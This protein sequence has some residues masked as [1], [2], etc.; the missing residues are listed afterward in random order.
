LWVKISGVRK[1]NGG[2]GI[3]SGGTEKNWKKKNSG[4]Q[5]GVGDQVKNENKRG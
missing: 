2:R 5:I 4:E 1:G 3:G